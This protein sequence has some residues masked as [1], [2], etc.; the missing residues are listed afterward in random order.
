MRVKATPDIPLA[1][2]WQEVLESAESL[3]SYQDFRI[4]PQTMTLNGMVTDEQAVMQSI[5]LLLSTPRYTSPIFTR[6][7]GTDIHELIGYNIDVVYRELPQM[8][9]DCLEVDD[10]I[11]EVSDIEIQEIE[12]G[13]VAIVNFVVDTIYGEYV[14]NNA[15]INMRG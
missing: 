13:R 11:K 7:I 5:Y 1:D 10:R 9:K 8:V 14:V 2:D 15:T 12:D 3:E 6:D 4:D